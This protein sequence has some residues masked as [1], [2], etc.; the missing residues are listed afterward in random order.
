MNASSSPRK[1]KKQQ[2]FTKTNKKSN[3]REKYA[4]EHS[5]PLSRKINRIFLAS[6]PLATKEKEQYSNRRWLKDI[7]TRPIQRATGICPEELLSSLTN[8][9]FIDR[10]TFF[11]KS[12][13]TLDI[14]T[15]HFWYNDTQIT[16][17]S[18]DY[19]RHF[20]DT[21]S[22]VI[23]YELS[24]Q[25]RNI[26]D[27]MDVLWV[28]LWLHPVRF[29]DDV[30]FAM[31]SNHPETRK[32][33][34][35]YDVS[36][37]QMALY[38]DRIRIQTYKG[39][40]R[41]E[42]KVKPNS[43][44]L[45]G[46]TLNDKSVLNNGVF[47]SLLDHKERIEEIARAHKT[48]YFARHPYLKKGDEAIMAYLKSIKNLEMASEPVYRM[49][50]NDKIRTVFG[51]SSS[52]IVEAK[53]FDKNTEF[54]YRPVLTYGRPDDPVSYASIFQD[55]ISPHFWSD[56]LA[57]M[58]AVQTTPV[59]KFV[60]PQDK[61]R[62]MLGFYWSYGDIDKV[63]HMRT[64]LGDIAK[65]LSANAAVTDAKKLESINA[66][67]TNAIAAAKQNH[68]EE[69]STRKPPTGFIQS[70]PQLQSLQREIAKSAMVSFD[71]F[72][73]LIERV[74]NKSSDL[75]IAFSRQAS[76]LTGGIIR[77][78]P[79]ARNEAR[80]LALDMKHGE[81]ILL[82]AR[83]Q[84]M[85]RAYGLTDVQRQALYDLEI[86]TEK[87]V[88]RPRFAG[89]TAFEMAKK[90]GK[91]IILVSD[92]YLTRDVVEMLLTDSGYQGWDRLY[93][94][95]EEGLLK[96]TG[97]LFDHVLK[98]EVRPA[99][100]ILHIG[101]TVTDDIE[102]AQSRGMRTW[103]LPSG[104]AIV[105]QISGVPQ[106]FDS[107]K[108]A[109]TRSVIQGLIIRQ[110]TSRALPDIPGHSAGDGH[111]LGY[112][113]MGP[114]LWGFAH[115]ILAQAKSKG[116]TDIYFLARDGDIIKRCFDALAMSHEIRSHYVLT[117]RRSVSVA[118]LRSSQDITQL[119]ERNF[120]PCTISVLLRNR[121]GID[122][123]QIPA[124]TFTDHGLAGPHARADKRIIE[125]SLRSFFA[126]TRVSNIILENAATER[127][128]LSQY[129]EESG[130]IDPARRI[131][132]VDI[133]H[134]GSLQADITAL[135]NLSATHGM[136]FAT[137]IEVDQTI[138]VGHT[139]AG[140]AA[141]RF[142]SKDVTHPYRRHILMFETTF[143][144]DVGSFVRFEERDGKR[145]PVLLP[146]E[147]ETA[148]IALIRLI[149]NGILA[150][151]KDMETMRQSLDFA[152][153]LDGPSAIKG[154]SAVFQ[155]P[156][157]IDA[158]LFQGVGFEN[159]YSARDMRWLIPPQGMIREE[160]LWT[161]GIQALLATAHPLKTRFNL[162]IFLADLMTSGAAK[163][164]KLRQTP[165]RFFQDSR[166]P[167]TRALARFV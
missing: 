63:E 125:T 130:M 5:Q 150:F 22:L 80:Q 101:D 35:S 16:Q 142:S 55:F 3:T 20:V 113:T 116:L 93:L 154:A 8:P 145:V 136:Y 108:D 52:V 14:D 122:A 57:P 7:L 49:L 70:I 54:L 119:L 86:T 18:I 131:G 62:D 151:V 138:P 38:A 103:F 94:S 84:A 50:S 40:R 27:R 53:Y 104:S 85:Q 91:R 129:Y 72:D 48:V 69:P 107:V 153:A 42:A 143:Q 144:N 112:V 6:D 115:W 19:L 111:Q 95:S 30:L 146:T 4:L 105:K 147:N 89:K 43:A 160:G 24:L 133:G 61:V 29:M 26:L 148:R 23:G 79:K 33:L 36:E 96:H 118:N 41:V 9:K 75:F 73:T 123:A 32:R 34:F 51:L 158:R 164:R 114:A 17:E 1:I 28:D 132:L 25:T 66:K 77:D 161:E 110:M 159:Q 2:N 100:R 98:T 162:L 97:R 12:G 139:A 156:W 81:E 163:K 102:K 128:L 59:V 152:P 106:A 31:Q 11:S 82:S 37:D 127:R 124:Q 64:R 15:T 92:M 134:M 109:V 121:F 117:S 71:I 46:Q 74:L 157:A 88:C 58:M 140:Y 155:A 167:I 99:D 67:I 90:A 141:D 135:M 137:Q 83:Y 10:R 45:V 165:K 126:D 78:F 44:L 149:H 56:I 47:M 87:A 39:W 65:R 13:I 21:N 68:A 166:N 120:T 60:S 76:E